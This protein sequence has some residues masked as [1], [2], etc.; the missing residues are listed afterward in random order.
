[1]SDRDHLASFGFGTFCHPSEEPLVMVLECPNL[2]MSKLGRGR[3]SQEITVW[4]GVAILAVICLV[5]IW[6]A[7][8]Y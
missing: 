1:V 8:R 2:P 4:I 7:A 3:L 5:V 6:F